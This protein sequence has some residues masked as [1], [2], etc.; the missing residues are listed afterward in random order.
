MNVLVSTAAAAAIPVA[1]PAMPVTP[2]AR[3]AHAYA[4][5]LHMERRILCNEIW[6]D[7]GAMAEKFV[8]FD[9]AGANWHLRHDDWKNDP[10]PSSRAAAVLD[11]VGVDWRGGD[12]GGLSHQDSGHRPNLPA[13]WPRVDAA[14]IALGAKFEPL[15]DRF[16][17]QRAIWAAQYAKV[18]AEVD[19]RFGDSG[20]WY[21]KDGR[22]TDE[23][24][25]RDK[26]WADAIARL[27]ESDA[28]KFNAIDLQLQSLANAIDALPVMSLEG[29]KAKALVAFLR[30]SP[31]CASSDEY[32]FQDEV[33]FQRLF[34]AVAEFCGLAGAVAAAGYTIPF[35]SSNED[36][37]A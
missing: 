21:D 23:G 22:I 19:Q 12:D 4:A 31:H 10:Q 3:A 36:E 26:F 5:W 8:F 37:E 20:P 35:A 1:A 25:A 24:E 15:L 17:A 13:G 16:F 27:V 33:G 28:E 7:M 2:D 14:L 6:P 32:Y 9:N 18:D 34:T 29:L 30:V 11:L